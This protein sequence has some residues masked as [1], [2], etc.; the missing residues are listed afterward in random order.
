MSKCKRCGASF[1]VRKRVQLKDADICW[2]CFKELG[3]EKRDLLTASVYLFDEIKDGAANYYASKIKQ[4]YT[5]EIIRTKS[6]VVSNYGQERDLVCTEEERKISDI[7]SNEF[8]DELLSLV[9][10]SDD[11]VTI[12]RGDWDIVRLK[13][14]NRAKWLMFPTYESGSVKHRIESPDDVA[15]Y[16]DVIRESLAIARKYE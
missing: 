3:F 4:R 10:V 9:R 2:K 5:D 12:K 14:T 15:Q 6:L 16:F 7:I 11:Y 1:L 13:Y 8:E